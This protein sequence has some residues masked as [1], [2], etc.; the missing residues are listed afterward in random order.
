MNVEWSDYDV[1]AIAK[2][3]NEIQNGRL[4]Y[5]YSMSAIFSVDVDNNKLHNCCHQRFVMYPTGC[6]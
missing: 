6:T 5:A 4:P 3:V 2:E 1:V